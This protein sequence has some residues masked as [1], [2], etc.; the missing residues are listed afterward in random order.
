V[1]QTKEGIIYG[2]DEFSASIEIE[3]KIDQEVE[4]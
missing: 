2:I 3:M 1:K 4:E